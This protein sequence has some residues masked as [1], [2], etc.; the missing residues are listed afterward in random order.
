M[1]FSKTED[2]LRLDGDEGDILVMYTQDDLAALTY[3]QAAVQG[4]ND[5][6]L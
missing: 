1:T 5:T 3:L 4:A 6:L 2:P